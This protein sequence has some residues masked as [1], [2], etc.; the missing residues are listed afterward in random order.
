MLLAERYS[1]ESFEEWK[2]HFAGNRQAIESMVNHTHVYDLFLNAADPEVVAEDVWEHV[3]Q[4]LF[5]SWQAAVHQAFPASRF[6]FGY[7]TEPDEYGPTITFW[8]ED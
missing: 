6:T 8:Q 4:T 5:V 7:A 2:Q 1:P 3:G